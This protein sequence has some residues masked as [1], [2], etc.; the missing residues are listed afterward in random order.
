M[1]SDIGSD[2]IAGEIRA[3]ILANDTEILALLNERLRLVEQHCRHKVEHEYPSVDV[4]QEARL[5]DRLVRLNDGPADDDYVRGVF[6][7][8]VTATKRQVYG[9]SGE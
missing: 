6:E 7:T 9:P 3:A 5:F 4:K 1:S 2:P 8:I